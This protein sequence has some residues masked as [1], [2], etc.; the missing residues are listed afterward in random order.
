MEA[1]PAAPDRASPSPQ[2]G[3][4]SPST[5]PRAKGGERRGISS[6]TAS[7]PSL[8]GHAQRSKLPRRSSLPPV[9]SRVP[10][11]SPTLLPS[12][13][14]S[15]PKLHHPHRTH[16]QN[17]LGPTHPLRHSVVDG[18]L[19]ERALDFARDLRASGGLAGSLGGT[20]L[21]ALEEEGACRVACG[22]ACGR[23]RSEGWEVAKMEKSGG[24]G[25][26]SGLEGRA[27][28]RSWVALEGRFD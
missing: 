20:E 8:R 13:S 27:K 5:A 11:R 17:S 12:A 23:G 2:D 18:T 14:P 4:C 28:G 24:E 3:W 10:A 9:P 1:E 21:L 16:A 6:T 7:T 19:D 25:A 22:W 15:P 26:G